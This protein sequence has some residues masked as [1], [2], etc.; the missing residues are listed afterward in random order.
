M[1]TA[2]DG[3]SV[4]H[5]RNR[6]KQLSVFCRV[7]QLG[8]FTLAAESLGLA[9]PTVSLHV[10]ALEKEFGAFLF[11]RKDVPVSLT[12]AGEDLLALVEPLVQRMDDLPHNLIESIGNTACNQLTLAATEV[13]TAFLLPPYVRRLQD[14]YP[15]I[16]VRVGTFRLR[17]ALT[18]LVSDE[19]EFSL[20]MKF[21]RP[22]DGLRFRELFPYRMVVIAGMDHP[23]AGRKKIEPQELAVWPAVT[24]PEHLD[25]AE[26]G[27]TGLRALNAN[28]K[29]QIEV[30]DLSATKRYVETGLGIAVVPDFCVRDSDRLSTI[31]LNDSEPIRSYGVYTRRGEY[32]SPPALQLLRLINP[33][34]S[35][36]PPAVFGEDCETSAEGIC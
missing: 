1:R 20:G 25:M 11:D 32:L 10:H 9:Q 19:V 29:S 6:L 22:N 12:L 36:T 31:S 4:S 26:D 33:S 7:A 14:R 3:Q 17:E 23:L 35:E 15:G 24:R 13:A 30:S 34:I 27:V 16:R 28:L 18:R 21:P 8:N 2:D 5:R